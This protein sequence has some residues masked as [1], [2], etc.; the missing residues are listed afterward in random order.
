MRFVSKKLR[1]MHST[2]TAESHGRL[3]MHG[4]S[5][6]PNTRPGAPTVKAERVARL[7]LVCSGPGGDEPQPTRRP[8]TS[9]PVLRNECSEG[10]ISASQAERH[11][12]TGAASWDRGVARE[13]SIRLG[14]I[15][16]VD[17]TDCRPAHAVAYLVGIADHRKPP[18]IPTNLI[19]A[20]LV[21]SLAAWSV[22]G[23]VG[24]AVPG[25][26][27]PSIGNAI[28][29]S[30][31]KDIAQLSLED[32]QGQLV[33]LN[34][35][36]GRAVLLAPFLTS[37]QE[38]CPI[39][40]AALLA[41][42][43]TIISERLSKKVAI[44]EI[45]V[46]PGRDTPQRMTAYARLTGS[47]WPLLTGSATALA[48]LWHYFGIYYQKVPEGSPPG[49]DWETHLPYTY[50]VE[51]SD[52]F[53]LLG[54]DLHE[55]FIAGG[56]TSIGKIPEKLRRLLDSQGK[57]DLRNPGGGTWTVNDALDTINWVLK[58]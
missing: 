15:Q 32:Q 25:P 6:R 45:T 21:A 3:H 9:G 29:K 13:H 14:S 38:E 47:T 7:P 36:K 55:R 4:R 23:T 11:T 28:N 43:R 5:Y 27:S 52:G 2:Q 39:T 12:A 10:A 1:L 24:A 19:C 35:F 51:H 56:M 31:P 34:Q 44:I 50:D 57:A 54:S 40:T 53:V 18:R 42:D 58:R 17:P 48:R 37:C 41:V 22:A 26:P 8:G 16:G 49:I 33:T 46:D 30:V 20:A